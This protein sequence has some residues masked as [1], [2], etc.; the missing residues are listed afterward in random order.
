MFDLAEFLF[1]EPENTFRQ[2][3]PLEL[4]GISDGPLEVIYCLFYGGEYIVF[5][6]AYGEAEQD[7]ADSDIAIR[8]NPSQNS[9]GVWCLQSVD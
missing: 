7:H 9:L 2:S 5:F 8:N 1:L 6:S 3:L 4:Q